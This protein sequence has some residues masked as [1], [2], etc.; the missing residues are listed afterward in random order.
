MNP[1]IGRIVYYRPNILKPEIVHAAL[2]AAVN[3]D[4]TVNLRVTDQNADE[5]PA[6]RVP[7][8]QDGDERPSRTYAHWMPY[9]IGQAKKTEEAERALA[10]AMGSKDTPS[11]GGGLRF[12]GEP[13]QAADSEGGDAS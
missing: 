10:Q 2:V 7:F 5:Y 1:T 13:Q 4:G 11:G 6:L 8:V 12:D 3:D 9:Q